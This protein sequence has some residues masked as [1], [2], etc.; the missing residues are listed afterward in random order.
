[1]KSSKAFFIKTISFITIYY[2][3]RLCLSASVKQ[4]IHIDI[5]V[6][7]EIKTAFKATEIAITL[8]EDKY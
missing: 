5:E 6:P 2:H 3:K 8:E 7:E 4:K 1:M